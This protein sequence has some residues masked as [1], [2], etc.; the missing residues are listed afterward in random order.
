MREV[1]LTAAALKRSKMSR[2][3]VSSVVVKLVVHGHE[4]RLQA[5]IDAGA[6][7]V[8]RLSMPLLSVLQFR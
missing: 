4:R 7:L 2:P 1:V 6:L 8:H 5:A 3:D